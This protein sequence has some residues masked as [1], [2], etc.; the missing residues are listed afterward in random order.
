MKIAATFAVLAFT[1]LPS[2]ATAQGCRGEH[3]DETASSCLPGLVW[4]DV[5]GTCVES[6]T[7]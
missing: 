2:L 3:I 6:P 4:D 1:L 5:A 7:S